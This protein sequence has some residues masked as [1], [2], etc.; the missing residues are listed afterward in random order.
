MDNNEKI[1]RNKDFWDVVKAV[2]RLVWRLAPN[3]K[4]E[5][6]NFRVLEDDFLALKSILGEIDRL[7]K[8]N[9]P[10]N[11]LFAKLYIYHLTMNIRHF[12]TT[13]LDNYPHSDLHRLLSKPLDLFF[14]SFY[15]D[16][17][18]NQLNKLLN[19][20]TDEEKKEVWNDFVK[21]KET[22]TLQFITE[23]LTSQINEA[24]KRFS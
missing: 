11:T 5:Y 9:L 4:G 18:D 14:Q 23:K 8:I 17:Q 16:L 3:D 2:K 7:N 22:F 20:K 6:S 21:Y 10:N 15:N 12:G 1:K 13:V 24:L 19:C